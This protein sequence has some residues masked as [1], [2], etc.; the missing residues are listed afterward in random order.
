M[1]RKRIVKNKIRL[2]G[3]TPARSFFI[4]P[5]D[6]IQWRYEMIRQASLTRKPIEEISKQFGYSRDMY[7]YYKGKFEAAGILGLGDFKPGPRR[8]RKRTEEIENRIIQIR[9]K[10]P[11]LNMYEIH[12]MLRNEGYDISPRSVGRTLTSHGLGLKKM[13]GKPQKFIS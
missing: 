10:R 2:V 7:F 9:F 6:T 8:P 3:D 1:G 13:K 5:A 4:N 11:E 12:Q